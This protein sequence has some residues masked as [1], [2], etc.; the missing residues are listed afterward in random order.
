MW[1]KAVLVSRIGETPSIL[2][3]SSLPTDC[4]EGKRIVLEIRRQ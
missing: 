3:I 2:I 4:M 1:K